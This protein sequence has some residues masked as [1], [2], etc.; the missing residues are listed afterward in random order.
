MEGVADNLKLCPASSTA[1]DA[2]RPIVFAGRSGG[3]SIDSG[4]LPCQAVG[5]QRAAAPVSAPG[6]ALSRSC[7]VGKT[8]GHQ[9]RGGTLARLVFPARAARC[10]CCT[11]EVGPPCSRQGASQRIRTVADERN[12]AI[13]YNSRP[14]PRLE[15]AGGVKIAIGRKTNGAEASAT[16]RRPNILRPRRRRRRTGWR[17]RCR[18]LACLCVRLCTAAGLLGRRPLTFAP[19]PGCTRRRVSLRGCCMARTT[20][21]A[22]KPPP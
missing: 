5:D 22:A 13:N 7:R 9:N 12:T 17:C 18:C 10:R 19:R 15:V 11:V 8:A 1:R 2:A 16:R 4:P 21:V 3:V 20:F 6:A 14:R